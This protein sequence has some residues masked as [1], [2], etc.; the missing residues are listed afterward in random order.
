M[1]NRDTLTLIFG[2][3]QPYGCLFEQCK[4]EVGS[5]VNAYDTLI[6]CVMRNILGPRGV[7]FYYDK[8]KPPTASYTDWKSKALLSGNSLL[9]TLI[10]NG[11]PNGNGSGCTASL[12]QLYED[13]ETYDCEFYC[14]SCPV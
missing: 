6:C 11:D 9:T 1:A 5:G 8:T 2:D 3:Y 10:H 4:A 13:V 14:N 12:L 7:K